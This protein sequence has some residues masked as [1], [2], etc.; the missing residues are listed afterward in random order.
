MNKV[1][2]SNYEKNKRIAGNTIML[3]F[4]MFLMIFIG[5][6]T[7]RIILQTLGEAD[8]GTFNA[9]GGV[10]AFCSVL[11][12]SV[13]AAIM[14][15]LTFS[16]GE[17]N[18]EKV[19]R[20]FTSSVILQV[21]LCVLIGIVV[22]TVGLWWLNSHMVIPEGRL[23]AA[24]WVLHCSLA[25][26]VVNLLSAPYNAVIVAHER[27]SAFA[28]ISIL[29]ALLKLAVAFALLTST[30]D[31]L[32][33]YAV[34]M[35]LVSLIVRMTYSTYCRHHFPEVRG[36]I[37][38]DKRIVKEMSGFVGWNFFSS[39]T[40]VF[41]NA[42]IN[43]LVN[44]FFGVRVNAARGVTGQVEG[45]VRPFALNF[46]SA[47]N[48]QLIKSYAEGN[49]EYTFDLVRKGVKIASL[50]LIA[51][52]IPIILECDYLLELWLKD[53]PDYTVVFV[54]IALLCI[55]VDLGMNSLRQL[56]ISSGKIKVYCIGVGILNLLSFVVSWVVFS[57][58][59]SPAGSYWC[60]VGLQVL[61]DIFSLYLC[62]RQ[63]GFPMGVF[64]K[65]VLL[66]IVFVA[67]VSALP[68]YLVMR[69][70]NPGFLR[71]VAVTITSTGILCLSSY[72]FAFTAG[73]RSFVADI[74]RNVIDRVRR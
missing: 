70:L 67:A 56:I 74:Y 64:I 51:L 50:L 35:L 65:D 1:K 45:T 12:G 62:K 20:V 27:M 59:G 4:R 25:I 60:L 26:M 47:L 5:L 48:P 17:G 54:R 46:L 73:E 10:I 43:L 44:K 69:L 11:T 66:R 34:L 63:E 39:G 53:V 19:H 14:R 57:F 72:F 22:E 2:E 37:V 40:S 61:V 30:F 15:F 21:L 8:Y 71:L 33:T 49:K 29:E 7:S 16:L 3:F 52:V 24:H 9:V 41:T 23:S 38:F 18:P 36:R 6:F 55:V 13:S 32:K 68:A 28:F 31:K 58:G 42:G